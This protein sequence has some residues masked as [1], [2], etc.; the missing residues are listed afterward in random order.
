MPSSGYLTID[1]WKHLWFLLP[2]EL[3]LRVLNFNNDEPGYSLLNGV[4]VSLAS[5]PYS[6]PVE[7]EAEVCVAEGDV[8]CFQVYTMNRANYTVLKLT[9]VKVPVQLP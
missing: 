7:G 6:E 9:N 2:A 4:S 3:P 8:F 1:F 5:G